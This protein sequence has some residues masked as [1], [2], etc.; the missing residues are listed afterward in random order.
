MSTTSNPD[1]PTRYAGYDKAYKRFVG[2]VH[3][4]REAAGTAAKAAAKAAGQDRP[5]IEIREVQAAQAVEATALSFGTP[6]TA[7]QDTRT[8]TGLVAPYGI[9][10]RTSAGLLTIAPDAIQ[11]PE[12]L[13]RIKLVDNHQT[14]AVAVGYATAAQSTDRGL[15]MTF[16]VARTAAGDNALLEASERTRD[17]FSVELIDLE[18]DDHGTVT[19]ATL[20]AVA[21]VAV[22]AFSDARVQ[23]PTAAV[24]SQTSSTRVIPR[25]AVQG[26][27]MATVPAM[28]V[29]SA[30]NTGTVTAER[31]LE[32]LY[33]AL[34]RVVTGQSSPSMEAALADIIN[35]NVYATVGQDS[36][37]GQL[38]GNLGYKRRFVPLLR[39][40]TLTSWKVKGWKWGVKP[41]VDDYAGDK[42]AIPS[43]SPT[44]LPAETS[45]ARLAGGHDLDRKFKDFGDTEFIQAYLEA[46][47]ESYARKSDAKARAFITAAASDGG[48]TDAGANVLAAALLAGDVLEDNTDGQ[49]PDWILVNRLDRRAL[50][51]VNAH[52]VPAFLEQLN[53]KPEQFIPSKDILQGTVIA[54]VKAAGTFY[55]LGGAP[56]RVEALDVAR[57]GIDEALF[58]YWATLLHDS[59]GIVKTTITPAA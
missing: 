12:D 16:T 8:L 32:D 57:G 22:P 14:P 37:V 50:L 27:A 25:R 44:V 35:T 59:K 49:T 54:G 28:L 30:T 15:E 11:L 48:A 19:K 31:P 7:A 43:N 6:V 38:W 52:D 2:G 40:G 5:S 39:P 13:S 42:T 58:G 47:T 20:S 34:H 56:I 3:D 17:A 55:E 26:T 10:G 41:E 1:Q 4:S 9:P 29:A 23:A 36:Y 33:A 51:D 24:A 53:V 46:M 18:V 45:A 21:Q